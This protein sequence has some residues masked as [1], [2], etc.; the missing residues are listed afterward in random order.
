MNEGVNIK[1]K[2]RQMSKARID[3]QHVRPHLVYS[4][5]FFF[6]WG[7]MLIYLFFVPFSPLLDVH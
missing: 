3:F 6:V 2:E 1:T 5:F 4:V 7:H